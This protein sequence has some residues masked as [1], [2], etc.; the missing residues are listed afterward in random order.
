[1][2]MQ[3]PDGGFYTG[4]DASYSTSGT[5]TNTETSRLAILA[6]YGYPEG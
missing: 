4:Y 1:M 3:A 5:S 6:L 2:R